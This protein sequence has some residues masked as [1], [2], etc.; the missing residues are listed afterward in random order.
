MKGAQGD[1]PIIKIPSS[2]FVNGS[3][4][5][6]YELVTYKA[7]PKRP[8]LRFDSLIGST[9]DDCFNTKGEIGGNWLGRC[10]MELGR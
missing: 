5:K 1:L 3:D 8:S 7:P 6:T 10:I 2:R 9:T 4:S